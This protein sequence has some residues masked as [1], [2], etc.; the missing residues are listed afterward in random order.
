MAG[1]LNKQVLG[2]VPAILSAR[3]IPALSTFCGGIVQASQALG[4]PAA[5]RVH[6]LSRSGA[7][8]QRP[9]LTRLLAQQR[10]LRGVWLFYEGWRGCPPFMARVSN[11]G[12]L[13]QAVDAGRAGHDRE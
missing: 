6:R 11:D 8:R 10:Q 13:R 4:R 1:L 12:G 2:I 3:L 5:L 9:W 7:S